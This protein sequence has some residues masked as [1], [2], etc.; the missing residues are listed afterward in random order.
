MIE[1]YSKTSD[2][3]VTID[4]DFYKNYKD[5]YKDEILEEIERERKKHE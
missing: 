1:T 4:K 3:E 5:K 2:R